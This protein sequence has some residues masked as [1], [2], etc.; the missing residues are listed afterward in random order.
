MYYSKMKKARWIEDIEVLQEKMA[1]LE[2]AEAVRLSV[3]RASKRIEEES[4]KGISHE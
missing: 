4:R 3:E 2:C 1:E